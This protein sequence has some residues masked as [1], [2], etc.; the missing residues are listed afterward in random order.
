MPRKGY[1]AKRDVLP[2][3]VYNSKKVT[4]LINKIMYSGK[5]GIAQKICYGAFDIIREK[6]GRDPLEVFE[7]ALNNVMPV[8][9]VKPRRVGGAT[10]QVPVEV[11]PERRQTLGIRWIIEFARKRS[12]RTMMEK[13]AAEIMDAA[14]NTGAS[15]K[16]R[17]D[18]HKM[19]EANKAFAHYRW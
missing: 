18:T 2:D 7:E 12:G 14:N 13:L 8:L 3:P 17:E 15:V 16:K 4:K 5:R 1:V 9:E 6:T 19:A 10:Y 11:R